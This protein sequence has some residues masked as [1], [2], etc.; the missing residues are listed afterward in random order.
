M[1]DIV[2]RVRNLTK[3]Y[4]DFCLDHVSF[5]LRAGHIIG[6]IGRN[7]AGKTTTLRSLLH[8]LHPDSGEIEFFGMPLAANERQI[9][10]QI[11][12]VSGSA[13]FYRNKKLRVITTLTKS[14]YPDAWDEEVYRCCL[15]RFS[16][17]ENKTPAQLSSGMQIKYA[18]SLALSHRARL[19]IFDEP[20]SGLDPVSREDLLEWFVT[21]ASEGK[22]LLF[23]TH[24]T[25][26]LDQC[27]D[28]ILLIRDGKIEADA[29]VE[30]FVGA[31]RLI[32]YAP[33]Q[34]TPAQAACIIGQRRVKG[35]LR[36]LIRAEAAEHFPASM[37]HPCDLES[38]MVHLEQGGN[39]TC[40]VC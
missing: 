39:A 35:G 16:L 5:S 23:S 34:L 2:L 13:G 28:D 11:G 14:F 24:I 10:R 1:D 4:P 38:V 9:R 12:F 22:T 26:D 33:D 30:D 18:I 36:A 20:T 25:S 31:Y 40:S 3:T 15:S 8:F 21:L 37:V 6:F 29:T 32:R 19:L 7:G 17:N 27:A